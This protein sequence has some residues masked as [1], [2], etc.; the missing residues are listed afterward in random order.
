MLEKITNV[1]LSLT[2]SFSIISTYSARE[3]QALVNLDNKVKRRLP[4]QGWMYQ[5]KSFTNKMLDEH[6]VLYL[7]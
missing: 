1:A 3:S 2:I 7:T 6:T 5:F 4:L